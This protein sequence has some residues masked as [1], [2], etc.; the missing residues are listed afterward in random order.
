MIAVRM[1]RTST[2]RWSITGSVLAGWRIVPGEILVRDG[3]IGPTA[4]TGARRLRLPDGWIV[5]PGFWDL[6]VNGVA[7][8]EIGDDDAEIARVAAALPAYGVTAFCPTVITRSPAAYRRAG[9]ALA[10]TRW[11][12]QGARN[13]GVHLEGPFLSPTRPGAHPTAALVLP[14]AA[15][16]A[17]LVDAFRPRIVTLAPE[18]DGALAAVTALRRAGIVAGIGHTDADAELCAR[19]IAHGARLLIHAFNA[20]PGISARQPGPVGAFLAASGTHIAVIADG[21]HLAPATLAALAGAAGRRLIAVS[22]AVAAAGAPA[23]TYQLGGRR[24]ISDGRVVRDHA[25]HLAGSARPLADGPITL[26]A[27]GRSRAA[28][29]GAAITAPRRLLGAPDPLA[30][31]SPA[32]LVILDRDLR[33]RAT[34]LGGTVAWQ[35]PLA[36]IDLS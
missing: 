23:G 18:L 7:G 2:A 8:A 4:G 14:E 11:P 13:L 34:L 21:I 3:T 9:V 6:Q 19:A 16:L 29:L 22:D 33:P 25:G 5:A 36:G 26:R 32:D 1:P 24:V 10:A 28:A 20:M 35:D 12:A 31:G 17:Q 15:R 27:A 30:P